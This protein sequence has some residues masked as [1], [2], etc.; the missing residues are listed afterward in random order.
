MANANIYKTKSARRR[1]GPPNY[2]TPR[3]SLI[4]RYIWKWKV[5]SSMSIHVSVNRSMSPYSTY[6]VLDKLERRGLIASNAHWNERFH[7]WT[8]TEK[9]FYSI[10]NCFGDLKEEGFGS[11]N[12]VHDRLVQAFHLG[13]WAIYQFPIVSLFSEQEMRRIESELYPSWVPRAG[14]HRPDGYT[15]ISSKNK[16]WTLAFEVELHAKSLQR[17]DSLLRYYRI[18][19]NVD[20]V[21]WLVGSPTIKNQILKAKDNIGDNSSNY[22]VFVDRD[23]FEKFGWDSVVTNERSE[24]LFTMRENFQEICGDTYSEFMGT[25]PAREGVSAHLCPAK[26]IGKTRC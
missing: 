11:E 25:S 23:H 4:L 13:E 6:K 7:I 15:Q 10:R 18:L 9:G 12:Q 14:D 20:Q 8:L 16:S 1:N 5:A 17:Y 26:V 2:S 24:N 19:K 3:D 22:H 21:F